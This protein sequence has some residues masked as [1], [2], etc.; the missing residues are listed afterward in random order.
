MRTFIRFTASCAI[1]AAFAA[2]A[3]AQLPYPQGPGMNP[4][5]PAVSPYLNLLRG[6]TSAGVNYYGLVRPEL[7]FRSAIRGL[8]Q[9]VGVNQANISQMTDQRTGL[10]F[11]GHTAVFLNT[12]GYFMNMSGNAAGGVGMSQRR[13]GMAGGVGPMAGVGNA[14][15]RGNTTMPRP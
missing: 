3:P 12:G 2:T 8:E 5:G 11:T 13:P 10:P 6:G 15:Y 9:Q 1:A 4:N 14:S 7:Q